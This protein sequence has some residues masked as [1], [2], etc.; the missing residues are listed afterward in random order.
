MRTV[1]QFRPCGASAKT[2]NK[3]VVEQLMKRGFTPFRA[4]HRRRSG[5]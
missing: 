5:R 2:T 3:I 1:Y 4:F